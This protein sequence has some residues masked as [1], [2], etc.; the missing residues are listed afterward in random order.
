[1]SPIVASDGGRTTEEDRTDASTEISAIDLKS[2]PE[3]DPKIGI[4][5][6]QWFQH[7]KNDKRLNRMRSVDGI[8]G[9][10]VIEALRI[11]TC[12]NDELEELI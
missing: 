8:A 7:I 9:M 1:M 4:I 2:D 11:A 10:P 5:K 6:K 3:I 12:I